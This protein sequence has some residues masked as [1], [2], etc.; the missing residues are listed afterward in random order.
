MSKITGVEAFK[1]EMASSWLINSEVANPMSIY[2]EYKL[3]RD[4]W[5]SPM[6]TVLVKITTE[7]GNYGW[8][9]AGGGKA[10]AADVINNFFK[11]LLIGKDSFDIEMLWDIMYRASIAYGR[12]G[13]VIEAISAVD[14][15]LYD[16]VGKISNLPVYKLLGGKV[17]DK[18]RIYPTGN[19]TKRHVK[20]GFK[21]AKLAMPYG[22][23]DGLKGMKKNEELVKKTREI[24][25][26]DG[27]IM[28]DC[29]MAWDEEYTIKMALRLNITPL[30][31]IVF[32]MI[33]LLKWMDTGF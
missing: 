30:I 1:F 16:V 18:I 33:T 28:L 26:S 5:M 11:R 21:D 15:A 25:G 7:S 17:R 2:P 9:W 8:G 32:F 31:F 10:E 27:N 20:R 23:A 13:I 12:K 4:T 3:T 24:I 22:P 19:D 6:A 14:T 29:Y